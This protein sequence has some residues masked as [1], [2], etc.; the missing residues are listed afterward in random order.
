MLRKIT[1]KPTPRPR[2]AKR[3]DPISTA[4]SYF[5]NDHWGVRLAALLLAQAPAI[6]GALSAVGAAILAARHYWSR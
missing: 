6:L 5:T 4:L 1:A 2:A 3:F